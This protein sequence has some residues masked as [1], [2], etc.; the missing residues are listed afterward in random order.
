VTQQRLD[1]TDYV[2]LNIRVGTA[3]QELRHP[4]RPDAIRIK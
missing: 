3:H 4:A 2:R 1:E